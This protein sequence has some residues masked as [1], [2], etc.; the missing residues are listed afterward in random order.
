MCFRPYFVRAS[1][2]QI[3]IIVNNSLLPGTRL[4]RYEIGSLIGKG[5][6]G[7]V[8]QA[9]D[10]T[11][12]RPVALKILPPEMVGNQD[13][14]RRFV[15]EARAASAL[16]HPN[17]LTIYEID[18]AQPETVEEKS[19]TVI[20]YIAM[21]FIDGKTLN[22]L[23]HADKTDFNTLLNYLAQAADG[24]AKAHAA[25]IVHRDLKP[26]NIMVT[27]DGFAKILDFG[28]AKL[29]E[30]ATDETNT[31]ELSQPL[32]MPG[33][34]LGTLGYMSPEQAQAKA[35]DQRSDIFSFGCI[36]Y[37]AV[38]GRKPF[39]SDSVINS[40][41]QIIN[42]EP[43]PV[44]SL[45]HSAPAELQSIIRRCL[46]KNPSERFQSIKD[47]AFELR[48][49]S[50]ASTAT[51]ATKMMISDDATLLDVKSGSLAQPLSGFKSR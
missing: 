1:V 48:S 29:I 11:L 42:D 8:F 37:E 21:E 22:R 39:E 25:G 18:Q 44:E 24:L 45:N 35:I 2:L 9:Q 51:D 41:Y 36:L 3:Q 31:Q 49:L 13:R 47:V 7:V 10:T 32:S 50:A 12:H 23:I 40:L 28:L 15:G 5:G 43:A 30:T 6:M 38:T 17:I 4:G 33:V 19:P 34:I 16:N 46:M 14:M 27:R 26:D 20:H